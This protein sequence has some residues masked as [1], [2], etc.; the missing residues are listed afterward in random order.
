MLAP[1]ENPIQTA[2]ANPSAS[3][4]PAASSAMFAAAYPSGSK[5]T[6]PRIL[7]HLTRNNVPESVETPLCAKAHSA[8]YELA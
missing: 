7:A 4:S 3:S 2:G 8:S 5:E 1:Q 6:S